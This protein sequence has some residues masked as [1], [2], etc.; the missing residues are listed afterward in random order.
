MIKTS[1]G[2]C[3]AEAK[4]D[5]LTCARCKV[6]FVNVKLSKKTLERSRA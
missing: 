2:G 5:L 1:C 3:G 4:S 6:N